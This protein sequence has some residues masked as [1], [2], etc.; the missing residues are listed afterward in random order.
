[1]KNKLSDLTSYC[2]EN[3]NKIKDI[4][5]LFK[6]SNAISIINSS[7]ININEVILEM[8]NALRVMS[9]NQN[10]DINANKISRNQTEETINGLDVKFNNLTLDITNL[11]DSTDDINSVIGFAILTPLIISL[12]IGGIFLIFY[13]KNKNKVGKSGDYF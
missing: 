8:A 6:Q 13:I 11:K 9:S 12:L 7:N 3:I 2:N 5:I 10:K 1:M 4:C